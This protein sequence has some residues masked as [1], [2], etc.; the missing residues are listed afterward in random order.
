MVGEPG[1]RGELVFA[2][3]DLEVDALKSK[4]G[5]FWTESSKCGRA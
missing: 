3:L 4:Q 1:E 5:E 2:L